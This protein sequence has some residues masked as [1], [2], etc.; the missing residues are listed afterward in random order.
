MGYDASLDK[1][2][3]NQE[4]QFMTDSQVKS[5]VPLDRLTGAASASGL[6]MGVGTSASPSTTA[7]ADA[8]FIELRCSSSA[9]SG[10][11]RLHYSEYTLTGG[12]GGECL[13]V[14]TRVHSNLGT[15][16]GAHIGLEFLGTAGTSECSGQ[17]AAVRGTLMIPN[18]ASWLPTGTYAAGM[19]EI[20]SVG[21]ASDP[22]GMTELSVLRLCNSGDA[23][24]AA[25][26]DTDAFL[27]SV[28][29]FTVGNETA[30]KTWINTITA[31]TINAGCTEA[32]KIKVGANTRYIPISTTVS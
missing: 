17:G 8:K 3:I 32:L 23:T 13:R 6:L 7:T 14:N 22:A 20:Y 9:T 21:T 19:F 28:Q 25:D 5:K 1:V 29:G 27:I 12:G 31:A 15:A 11:N 30:N 2:K 26:V 10:D 4:M 18:I 16:H 24:G